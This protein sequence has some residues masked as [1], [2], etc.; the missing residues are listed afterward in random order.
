MT[1]LSLILKF[2]SVIFLNA[3]PSVNA[4]TKSSICLSS[5]STLSISSSFPPKI[6]LLRRSSPY[7]FL[8]AVSSLLTTSIW[9][10]LLP[11][12]SVSSF[13]NFLSAASS[14]S[15]LYT[16]SL[17]S[18]AS[19]KSSIAFACTSERLKRARSFALASA[20][21]SALFIIL[22]T[23]SIF[24]TATISPSKTCARSFA[25]SK[26]NLVRLKTTSRW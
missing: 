8:I 12:I 26:S 14:S 22:I 2:F 4:T 18:L 21:L 9:R 10:A 7:F 24:L 5:F 1:F 15:S 13:I 3:L 19:L 20:V 11:A 25:R 17:V 23:S 6:I 16:S